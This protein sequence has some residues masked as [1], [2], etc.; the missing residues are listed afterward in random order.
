MLFSLLKYYLD[1]YITDT[2]LK[3]SRSSY[4]FTTSISHGVKLVSSHCGVQVY[5]MLFSFNFMLISDMAVVKSHHVISVKC[6]IGP[7]TIFDRPTKVIVASLSLRV[8]CT[9]IQLRF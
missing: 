2:A 5:P 7:L 4:F 8:I 3:V 6:K 9:G 1:L